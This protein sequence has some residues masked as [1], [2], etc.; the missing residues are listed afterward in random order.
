LDKYVDYDLDEVIDMLKTEGYEVIEKSRIEKF[1]EMVRYPAYLRSGEQNYK[2]MR[3]SIIE[4][5]RLKLS[6]KLVRAMNDV[7]GYQ[8]WGTQITVIHP[9][10]RQEVKHVEA[11]DA[12]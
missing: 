11:G 6:E 2:E 12:A 1:Q 9:K 7:W 3:D 4:Y 10:P 8:S 5:A